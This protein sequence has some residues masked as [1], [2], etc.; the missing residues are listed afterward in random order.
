MARYEEIAD[1]RPRIRRDVL[2]TRT[3]TGVLF[4][5]AHGGFSLTTKGA[6]RFASLLV[7]HLNGR[8]SVAELCAGMGEPQRAM[9]AGLVQALYGR[10]FARDAGPE[11]GTA[12]ELA[13]EVAARFA[14]QVE[15]I[16]HYTDGAAERFARYR[17]TRVAVLGEGELARWAV[18]SLIRN[19]CAAVG[20][21]PGL[22]DG[23]ERIA[24]ELAALAGAGCPAEL[25]ELSGLGADWSALADHELVLVAGGPTAARR[26]VGLLEAGVPAGTR[27]VPAWTVG[28]RAVVG[29][30]TEPGRPGCL[31]CAALRLGANG[32]PAEAAELWAGL[33]PLAPLGG[34]AAQPAG[35]LAAMLGNLLGYEV[36]RLTTGALPAETD[37]QLIVQDLD[38]LDVVCEPLLP[39]PRCPRCAAVGD[40][41]TELPDL[42]TAPATARLPED[43]AAEEAAAKAA[44]AELEGRAVLVR[45]NAGVFAGYADDDWQQTPLKA[46]TVTLGLRAGLRREITAFDVHHVAGARL[47]ALQRA[48]EVYAEHVVPPAI[49]AKDPSLRRYAATELSTSAGLAADPAASWSPA[50]SLLSGERVLVP[51]AALRPFSAHNAAAAFERTTAGTGAG[52]TEAEA[53]T[54]AL[55]SALGYDAL[56]AALRGRAPVESVPLELFAADAELTFL[57]RSAANLGLAPELLRLGGPMAPLPVVLARTAD[58]GTPRWTLGSGLDLAAA[59]LAALRELLGQ[60]QLG[61]DEAFRARGAALDLGDPLLDGFDAGVL[62]ATGPVTSAGPVASPGPE[63]GAAAGAAA[64]TAGEAGPDWPAVLERLRDA[65]RDVLVSRVGASDLAAGRLEVVKVLLTDGTSGAS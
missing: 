62:T 32:E 24:A 16:D 59:A 65:G 19:G 40:T 29:P 33:A 11:A 3:P 64:G 47:R 31:T 7:P 34:E 61:R 6:Y 12:V 35:P 10:G 25:T 26:T 18:L 43:G 21:T 44:L 30:L 38:S 45:A 9:V 5:N 39:H 8:H 50:V 15:Y 36:F 56:Q 4:H 37:G 17:A 14:A 20:V 46:G 49:A 54:R 42:A 48:A 41:A 60:V 1:S 28:G 55:G 13:P 63:A 53:V 57:A 51:T 23:D 27:L 2:Y 22:V 52:G 58:A